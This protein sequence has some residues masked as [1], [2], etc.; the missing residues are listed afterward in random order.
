MMGTASEDYRL[1]FAIHPSQTR[2]PYMH[3]HRLAFNAPL[4]TD[5]KQ[6]RDIIDLFFVK[7]RSSLL[8][9]LN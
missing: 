8:T 5:P 2:M 4:D 9:K 6:K 3:T 1:I 7:I